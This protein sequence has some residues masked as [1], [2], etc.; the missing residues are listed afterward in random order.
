MKLVRSILFLAITASNIHCTQPYNTSS[1]KVT[2]ITIDTD[3]LADTAMQA[4]I[5]PYRIEIDTKMDKV[6][7]Q[8]ETQ[9]LSY[10]PESPL[11]NFIS[12][13]IQRKA[14]QYLSIN[15]T[16]TLPLLT[17]MNIKGIRSAIPQGE[18]TL[19]NIFELMPFEN[20]IVILTLPGDSIL[21]LFK[22]LGRTKGDGIAG[23]SVIFKDTLVLEGRV[24]NKALDITKNYFL[25]TSDYLADGG[26]HYH[27]LANPIHRANMNLKLRETIIESIQEQNSNGNILKADMD[28]RI[29]F[30]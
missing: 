29:I 26:D 9:M 16:D 5:E 18:V 14:H 8:S 23:A 28:G 10:K 30:N 17:L 20:E 24:G 27:M 1:Y 15:N 6:I 13:I 21:S 7:G 3:I 11:S 12:D 2:N 22:F 4:E 25:A 19:R